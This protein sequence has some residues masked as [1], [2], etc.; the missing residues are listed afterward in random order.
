[1]KRAR[2][3]AF[4]LRGDVK[5]VKKE[6]V[7]VPVVPNKKLVLAVMKTMQRIGRPSSNHLELNELICD[8]QT[9]NNVSDA[10]GTMFDRTVYLLTWSAMVSDCDVVIDE[11]RV[12]EIVS[13]ILKVRDLQDTEDIAKY[14]SN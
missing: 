2:E 12:K 13:L 14:V 7:V 1:M 6:K 3:L 5:E 11:Q 9:T 10:A 8:Y 4:L